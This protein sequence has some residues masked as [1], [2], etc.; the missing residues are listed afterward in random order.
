MHVEADEWENVRGKHTKKLLS[1][2]GNSVHAVEL[3]AGISA[4]VSTRSGGCK[5]ANK[6]QGSGR[7]P[8]ATPAK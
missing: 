8:P 4:R 2:R 3:H 1:P 7:G 6:G 5:H